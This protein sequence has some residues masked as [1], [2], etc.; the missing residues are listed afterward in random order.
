MLK[1][2]DAFFQF[3]SGIGAELALVFSRR[4]F[5]FSFPPR[6]STGL[7]LVYV[8][9]TMPKQTK[10]KKIESIAHHLRP[11]SSPKDNGSPR[12]STPHLAELKASWEQ[13]KKK[14]DPEACSCMAAMPR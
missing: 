12:R 11:P 5:L 8:L 10:R 1:C 3:N 4:A 7:V 2:V 14:F 9:R 6:G 13:E